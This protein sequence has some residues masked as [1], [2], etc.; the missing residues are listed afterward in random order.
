ML[1][2]KVSLPQI[3]EVVNLGNG[4]WGAKV[5]FSFIQ[6]MEKGSQISEEANTL[7]GGSSG[8]TKQIVLKLMTGES[9]L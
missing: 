5:L 7:R 4:V 3:N 9:C 1:Y 6:V 8:I 2:L